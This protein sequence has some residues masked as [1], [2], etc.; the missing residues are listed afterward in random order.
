[1]YK[2][3]TWWGK[4]ELFVNPKFRKCASAIFPIPAIL[5]SESACYMLVLL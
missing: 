5:D 1:M 3:Q 2:N 4:N